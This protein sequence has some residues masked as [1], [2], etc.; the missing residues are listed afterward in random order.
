MLFYFVFCRNIV[1][2]YDFTKNLFHFLP[3]WCTLFPYS[4]QASKTCLLGLC[5]S[6]NPFFL[7][8]FAAF[9]N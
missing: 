9:Q 7:V 5:F 8:F 2:F 3:M 1:N 6:F 4:K